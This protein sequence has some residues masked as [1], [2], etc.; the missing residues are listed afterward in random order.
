MSD[1]IEIPL[2]RS[3]S[4]RLEFKGAAALKRPERIGREVAAMLNSGGGEVWIGLG[5]ESTRAVQVEP[6]ARA[7]REAKRLLDFLL[8]SLSPPVSACEV[9]VGT[10]PTDSTQGQSSGGEVIRIVVTPDPSK[11]PYALTSSSGWLFVERVQDRLRPMT[12]DEVLDGVAKGQDA[13]EEAVRQVLEERRRAQE[14]RHPR[15]WMAVQPAERLA[16]EVGGSFYEELDQ[17]LEDPLRTNNRRSGWH[18]AQ[19][20]DRPRLSS[21]QIEWGL[22]NPEHDLRQSARIIESGGMR[23]EVSLRRLRHKG[24]PGELWPVPLF[25]FPASAFRIASKIYQGKVEEACTVVAD[26]ALFEARSSKLRPG[27]P[28]PFWS[29]DDAAVFDETSDLLSDHPLMFT[30]RE[31]IENPDQCAFRLVRRVYEAFGLRQDAILPGVYDPA[32]G[33]LVLED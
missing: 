15:L 5:E 8:D 20:S 2:G 26:L 14:D 24:E 17:L 21:G 4:Q 33:R 23:F 27:A 25:E 9:V 1:P 22:S 13:S 11:R 30:A 6:I 31:V 3:E 29:T 18:F 12:R 7:D 10:V 28:G 16:L 19:I 32:A